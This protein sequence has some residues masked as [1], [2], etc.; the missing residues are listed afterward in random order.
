LRK[1]IRKLI[2]DYLFKP[3]NNI[4]YNFKFRHIA[5]VNK[6]IFINIESIEGWYRGNKYNEFT[7]SGIIKGGDWSNK[8]TSRTKSLNDIT[9]YKSIL[10]RY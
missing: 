10:E 4:I 6:S 9:K 5:P 7:F 2:S 1:K 8:I 3:Y